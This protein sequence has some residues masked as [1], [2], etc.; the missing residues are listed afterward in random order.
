[1]QDNQAVEK[2]QRGDQEAFRHLVERYHNVLYG[3]AILMTGNRGEAEEFVQEAF[4]SAWRGIRGFKIGRPLKPWLTRILINQVLVGKR[5]LSIPTTP[6]AD[7]D[8]PGAPSVLDD[9]DAHGDRAVVRE[10][11][12]SLEPDHRQV[13][14]LRYFTDL[15][16]S[17]IAGSLGVPEGTV[18][19]RISR[20][21]ARLK[22][23]LKE[24]G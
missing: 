17:E 2:C 7:P 8:E 5:R 22:E 11:V 20:A 9:V 24:G 1:M 21:I 23:H 18:K 19:S 4:L 6:L 3:T 13:I 15:T 10:A 16:V 14:V 12:A